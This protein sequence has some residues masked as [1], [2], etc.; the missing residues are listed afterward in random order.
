M[1]HLTNI[2]PALVARGTGGMAFPLTV[3][4]SDFLFPGESAF[5]VHTRKVTSLARAMRDGSAL[6]W[7]HTETDKDGYLRDF[8]FDGAEVVTSSAYKRVESVDEIRARLAQLARQEWTI[9]PMPESE[10]DAEIACPYDDPSPA[11][12]VVTTAPARPVNDKA[13]QRRN[14]A[15]RIIA[16]AMGFKGTRDHIAAGSP[17]DRETIIT[18]GIK[19][20]KVDVILSDADY[21]NIPS[22]TGATVSGIR[23]GT[24]DT[25]RSA[26]HISH[27]K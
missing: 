25:G 10:S 12:A 9:P 14:Y 11:S 19:P 8:T 2:P 3:V 22:S 1:I 16:K 23:P 27:N 21:G 17:I 5:G 15:R 26:H 6:V 13:L 4:T 20:A 7:R 18:G 24:R